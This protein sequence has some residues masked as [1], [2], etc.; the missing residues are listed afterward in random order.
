VTFLRKTVST[1]TNVDDG[2]GEHLSVMLL[3]SPRTRLSLSV[4]KAFSACLHRNYSLLGIIL[5]LVVQRISTIAHT[6]HLTRSNGS[7]AR[8]SFLFLNTLR[9][10]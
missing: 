2:G 3:M 4:R 5:Y 1:L 8:M 7:G 6:V 10:P 9:V